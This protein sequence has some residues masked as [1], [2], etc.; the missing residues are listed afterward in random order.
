[1]Q[2][3]AVNARNAVTAV[4]PQIPADFTN[5]HRNR[6]G[7]KFHP[8]TRIKIIY[9]LHQSDTANLEQII[10]IFIMIIKPFDHG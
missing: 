1:M 5:N 9:C 4:I 7:G 2:Y 10:H 6:I 3:H 8:D